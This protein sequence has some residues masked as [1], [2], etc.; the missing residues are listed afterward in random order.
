MRAEFLIVGQG[1]AGTMLAWTLLQRGRTFIIVDREEAITSSKVAGGLVTPITGMRLTLNWRYDELY[2]EALR[3]YRHKERILGRRLFFPRPHVRLLR[4]EREV[5]VWERRKLDE[6]IR[7]FITPL[8]GRP[9]VDGTRISAPLGGFQ[10]SHS[11]FLDSAAFIAHSRRHFETL[12]VYR[13]G[14]VSEE[15]LQIGDDG[16][17]WEG[18]DFSQVALCQGWE[19]AKSRWF[20]WLPFD[21]T[22]GT[23]LSLRAETG[24]KRR[25]IN[26]GCWVV[27]RE[28]GSMMAGSTY[29]TRFDHPH[30]PVPGGIEKLE[31]K[32]RALVRSDVEVL[33][34]QTAVRPGIKRNKAAVGRHPVQSRI[35]LMNGLGSKGALRG[36]YLARKLTEHLIDG[37]PLEAEI[38]LQSNL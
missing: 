32:L 4:N 28:D 12:G 15:S 20:S 5:E 17:G 29:E 13:Q 9:L 3:F 14:E 36:P 18:G 16:I 10:Q 2:R 34:S 19:V 35:V 27:T 25:I 1:L 31:S 11:G 21:H 23:V 30:R 38:D 7:P 22:Q 8:S 33:G 24:E 26:S 37:A 6:E